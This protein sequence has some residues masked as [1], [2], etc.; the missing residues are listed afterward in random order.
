MLSRELHRRAALWFAGNG[1]PMPALRHAAAAENWDL[2]GELFV[3]TAGPRILSV[4]R[5][6]INEALAQIPDEELH[7][8]AASA[9]MRGRQ[10]GV[11]QSLRRDTARGRRGPSACSPRTA[12]RTGR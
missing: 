5:S 8:S 4:D 11:R 9:D 3:T 12:R 2:L 7:R 6:A 1:A 10:A